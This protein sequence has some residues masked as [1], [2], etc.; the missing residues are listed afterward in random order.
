MPVSS[1]H[2]YA[3]RAS[4]GRML[5]K[6][7]KNY[8]VNVHEHLQEQ[9]V[10]LRCPRPPYVIS[11]WFMMAD[12]RRRDVS[13]LVKALEDSVATFFHYDDSCHYEMHLYK[14]LDIADPRAVIKLEHKSEAIPTP[15]DIPVTREPEPV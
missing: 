6:E 10:R 13:N 3:N 1:N 7:G 4:G 8:K 14:A 15:P 2:L 12:R 11:I 9:K 5:S